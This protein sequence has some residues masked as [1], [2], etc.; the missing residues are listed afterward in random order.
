MTTRLPSNRMSIRRVLREMIESAVMAIVLYAI[1]ST[2]VARYQILNISMEPNFHE[3]QLV[4]VDRLD[5]L[6]PSWLD[7]VAH[8][9]GNP[10]NVGSVQKRGQVVVFYPTALHEGIPLIKRVIGV[11]GDTLEIANGQVYVNM[12]QLEEPYINGLATG[13]SQHCS[14]TLKPGQYFV[15]GDNRPN[16]LDS[17]SFGP[18]DDANVIGHV[19]LR[20]W[21]LDRLEFFP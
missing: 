14:M 18:V 19:V 17:R 8:A 16:S 1:I 11:P 3:G 9:E 2:V 10:T 21:P 5:S 20:Y 6:L 4:V 12:E 13:C 7:G 15:M